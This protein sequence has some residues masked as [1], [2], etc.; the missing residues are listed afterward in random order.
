M[1]GREMLRW[2]SVSFVR[3]KE[4]KR[5]SFTWQPVSEGGPPYMDSMTILATRRTLYY[6]AKSSSFVLSSSSVILISDERKML[7]VVTAVLIR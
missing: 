5:P 3:K 7:L 4:Q 6:T 1:P 2:T